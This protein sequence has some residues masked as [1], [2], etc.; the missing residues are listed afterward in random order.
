MEAF[1]LPMRE[2]RKTY[3]KSE[4][5]IMSWRSQ[6]TAALMRSRMHTNTPAASDENRPYVPSQTVRGVEDTGTAYKLPNDVNNG[7]PIPKKFFNADGDLDLSQATG[8][9]AVT[10]LKALGL[11]I[12]D[13]GI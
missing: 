6:E 10:Y 9:E 13:M 1:K 2:V 11:N 3:K 7:V 5:S 8:R 4:L 12:L